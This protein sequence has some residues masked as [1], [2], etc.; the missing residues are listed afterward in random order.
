MNSVQNCSKKLL[1]RKTKNFGSKLGCLKTKK[2]FWFFAVDTLDL[3]WEAKELEVKS[4]R[5]QLSMIVNRRMESALL[6]VSLQNYMIY[7][8]EFYYISI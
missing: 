4:K 1:E 7:N 2:F 5:A 3:A 8:L 6:S